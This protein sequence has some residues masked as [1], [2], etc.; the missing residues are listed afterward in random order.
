M[1]RSHH[2]QSSR[3]DAGFTLLEMLISLVLLALALTLAAQV[4]IE[5][6]QMLADATVEQRDPAVPLVMA[7]LKAEVRK[8]TGFAAEGNGLL[9]L[10]LPEGPVIYRMAGGWLQRAVLD[11][12]GEPA[13]ERNVLRGIT[14]WNC[15]SIPNPS[16][17]VSL[18]AVEIRYLQY[19]PR[20]SPLPGLPVWR[21]PTTRE[22]SEVFFVAPR[23]SGMGEAW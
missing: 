3:R 9:L 10:G 4:L 23:G 19:V 2:P 16:G 13:G 1:E 15:R 11:S 14:D 17:T 7:R 22:R 12:A 8:S 6:Q 18:L 21:G 20:K 5:S